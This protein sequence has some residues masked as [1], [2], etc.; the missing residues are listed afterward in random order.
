MNLPGKRAKGRLNVAKRCKAGAK[1]RNGRVE[2]VVGSL[3]TR[4]RGVGKT[5]RR[6]DFNHESHER[7]R[8]EWGGVVVAGFGSFSCISEN[9]VV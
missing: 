5:R 6:G 9:F 7:G 4:R 8:G 3:L 2:R 1:R